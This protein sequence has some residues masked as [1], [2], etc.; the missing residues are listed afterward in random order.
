MVSPGESNRMVARGTAILLDLVLNSCL[1]VAFA[2][3][4]RDRIRAD[5]PFASPSFLVVLM[6]AAIVLL[7]MTFYLYVWHPAWAWMYFVDPD[8]VPGL[9]IIPL[10][11]LHAGLLIGGWYLAARL[12]RVGRGR[13]VLYIL[14]TGGFIVL[15]GGV[16]AWSRLGYVGTF[17]EYWDEPRRA[18]PIMQV[19]LGYVMIA[20]V[21]GFAVAAG[22]AALELVR[23]SRRVRSR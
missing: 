2:L 5:G 23:D 14:A 20:M 15:L 21:L 1:G 22:M 12:I 16:L 10:C 19:K 6:F 4:A 18:L 3:C 17:A 7:P 9:A 13:V 11:F 8:N